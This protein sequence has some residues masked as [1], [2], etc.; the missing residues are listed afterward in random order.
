MKA[1]PGDRLVIMG[2]VL[3]EHAREGEV[4][5]VFG[6]AGAPPYRVRWSEDGH[7]TLLFPGSDAKV[8]HIRHRRHATV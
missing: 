8:E 3:N 4:L 1:R 2:H 6:E 5:E 7:E